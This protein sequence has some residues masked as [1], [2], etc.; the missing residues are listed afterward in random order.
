VRAARALAWRRQ[1]KANAHLKPPEMDRHCRPDRAGLQLLEQAMQRF[2]L[3]HRAYH[4]IL[5][6]ARTVADLAG[7]DAIEVRHLSEAIGYRCLD[8]SQSAPG[9]PRM[10]ASP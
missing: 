7:S 1:H 3:S 2:G 6:V 5:K 9:F 4:R 8:R 10:P